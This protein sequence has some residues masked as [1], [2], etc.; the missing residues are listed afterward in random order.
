VEERGGL[1]PFDVEQRRHDRGGGLPEPA[2]V[3]GAVV[4]ADGHDALDQV[5]DPGDLLVA[6]EEQARAVAELP[7]A[8]EAGVLEGEGRAGEPELVAAVEHPQRLAGGE[9]ERVEAV[10]LGADLGAQRGGVVRRQPLDGRPA[11]QQRLPVAAWPLAQA[12]EQPDPG[13]HHPSP[14][15]GHGTT[16]A[17]SR[18][19]T[20]IA[21]LLPPKANALTIAVRT[22]ARRATLGT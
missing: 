10:D 5:V 3:R 22:R 17:S 2:Q 20:T 8:V 4:A 6:A 15:A 13:Q 7:A 11:L 16:P 12:G 1:E 9:P 18:S 14:R 19:P 21:V